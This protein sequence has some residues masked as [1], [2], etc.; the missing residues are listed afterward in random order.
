MSQNRPSFL[1]SVSNF[2]R[3][4]F[5]TP[6]PPP[7]PPKPT[8]PGKPVITPEPLVALAPRVLV[9]VYDP[10][11]DAM[12]NLRLVEWGVK[13]RGWKRVDELIAGYIADV[14]GC[15]GGLVKYN[16]V[17]RVDV[18][19]FP[20]KQDGFRYT[21][22]EYL[23]MYTNHP[24]RYHQ[25]DRID[26]YKI[27][28]DFKLKERVDK[29]E[30]DEVWLFTFPFSGTYESI[31]CG[32]GAFWCNAPPLENTPGRRYVIMGYSYERGIGEM[33]EDLGHRME[34][35]VSKIYN[36]GDFLGWTYA[37]DRS[38]VPY[39]KLEPTK[40]DAVKYGETNLFGKFLLYDRIA[41]GN[42]Q[43]G[44]V[45]YAPN[46][47]K[48]YEWGN[49]TPVITYADDW[50]SFPNLARAQKMENTTSWGGGE[51]RAHH[52]WWFSRFPK[53]AGRWNGIRMNWWSYICDVTNPEFDQSSG[54]VSAAYLG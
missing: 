8:E 27:I 24:D 36:A 39:V 50:L 13:N 32:T 29:K 5:G 18:P 48:D 53:V 31:M 49:P 23:D 6:P 43:C 1:G 46:S 42:A 41:P 9:I 51:I 34:S 15:S 45:H 28:A 7:P 19:E 26:Y 37:Y 11:V 44:N 52:R 10:V 25:P 33:E 22:L 35:L 4:L 47:Q 17:E 38:K 20:V 40:F 21:A 16:V 3:S 30:I 54:G 12:N 14:D 2:F